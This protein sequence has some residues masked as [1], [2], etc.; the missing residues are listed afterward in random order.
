MPTLEQVSSKYGAPM[1]RRG[2]YAAGE[3]TKFSLQRIRLDRGGYDPCGAYWGLG[4]PLYWA[5][6]EET[7][8]EMFLRAGCRDDAKNKIR[9]TYPNATFY[10]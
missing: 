1:G 5:F 10:R 9:A 4:K 2:N 3:G 6:C 7:S 8:A